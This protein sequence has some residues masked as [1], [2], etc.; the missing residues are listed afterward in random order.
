[1]AINSVLLIFEKTLAC[2]LRV[3]IPREWNV[4]DMFY[5]LRSHLGTARDPRTYSLGSKGG[6]KY[7]CHTHRKSMVQQGKVAN[8]ARGQLNRQNEYFPVRVR[9]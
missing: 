7:D 8:P 2:G 5:P 9:A 1:M 4:T 3:A 6:N